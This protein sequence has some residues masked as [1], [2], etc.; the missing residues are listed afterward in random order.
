MDLPQTCKQLC[1]SIPSGPKHVFLMEVSVEQDASV[2]PF[3]YSFGG[4]FGCCHSDPSL[5]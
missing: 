3:G 1:I 5:L 2:V 4:F